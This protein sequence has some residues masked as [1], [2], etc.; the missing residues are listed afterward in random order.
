LWVVASRVA[1][2]AK[3]PIVPRKCISIKHSTT[4]PKLK[5]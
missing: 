3:T 1:V 5:P 2:V 4:T